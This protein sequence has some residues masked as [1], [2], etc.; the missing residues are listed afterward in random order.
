MKTTSRKALSILA[1]AMMPLA[2]T[3]PALASGPEHNHASSD[4][5]AATPTIDKEAKKVWDKA[6][7]ASIGK[8]ARDNAIK[9]MRLV[10]TMSIPSQGIN[11]E[12]NVL[13]ATDQGMRLVMEIP[14]LGAFEQGMTG[15]VAWSSNMMEG[16]KILEGAEAEQFQKQGDIYADLHWDQYYQSITYIGEETV[17]MPDD[18]EI[19]TNALELRSI[20]DGT[21]STSYYNAETGLLVKSVTEV[22]IAGGAKIPSTSYTS[23]YREVGGS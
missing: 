12:M 20:T 17:T 18:S 8:E 1:A 23:D 16:P 4:A 3:T 13:I 6:L 22:T 9:S 7:K 15:D 11:A 21:V 19:A 14:G 5:K 10:G 2:F